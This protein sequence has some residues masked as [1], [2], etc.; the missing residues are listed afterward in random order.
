MAEMPGGTAFGT[1][2][3]AVLERVDPT[4]DDLTAEVRSHIQAQLARL[5]PTRLDVTALTAA[6]LPALRTP[7]GPFADD[8]S[9]TDI[10][11]VRPAGRTR[12]RTAA[13]RWRPPE[14]NVD[15]WPTRR[16]CFAHPSARRR[17]ARRLC[18][19]CSADPALGD[20]MLKGYLAGSI[21]AVLRVDERY[22]VVDY[23]TNRLGKPD[24]LLT[25][26]TTGR[27]AMADAMLRAHYPLQALLYEVALHRFLRWRLAD[28]EPVPGSRRGA[29]PLPARHVRTRRG[30]R[31]RND[32]LACSRGSR[33]PR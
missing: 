1:L 15:G 8:R 28:Y 6:L 31:R 17:P 22:V 25:A 18:R 23:K 10:A 3:H 20:A 29:V 12:L 7:L 2:V 5:G 11:T 30:T 21:D 19:L 27:P 32:H 13:V 16:R 9:L 24:H 14:R 4:A 26:W 33:R